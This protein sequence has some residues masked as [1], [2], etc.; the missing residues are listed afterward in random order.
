MSWVD[1]I[2]VLKEVSSDISPETRIRLGRDLEDFCK[3]Y[4]DDSEVPKFIGVSHGGRK[5][6]LLS[7]RY[8]PSTV[9]GLEEKDLNRHLTTPVGSPE[10]L[11]QIER[12]MHHVYMGTLEMR[13]KIDI[14]G[15]RRGRLSNNQYSTQADFNRYTP[16][17]IVGEDMINSGKTTG[18]SALTMTCTQKYPDRL[19]AKEVAIQSAVDSS[20]Y[21]F[22]NLSG[23]RLLYD[24]DTYELLYPYTDGVPYGPIGCLAMPQFSY[25]AEKLEPH[26]NRIAGHVSS[27]R[28]DIPY[29]AQRVTPTAQYYVVIQQGVVITDRVP[30]FPLNILPSPIARGDTT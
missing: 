10:Y 6:T 19:N 15:L 11:D 12:L 7:L 16:L 28:N 4:G 30:N 13:G 1:F 23:L 2:N 17:L 9:H 18:I 27:V 24:P 5:Q 26:V 14:N 22:P 21:G 20:T 25:F 8:F 3:V 29:L